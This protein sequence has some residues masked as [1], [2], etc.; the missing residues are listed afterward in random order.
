MKLNKQTFRYKNKILIEKAIF[1][2][3]YRHERAVQNEGC[4]VYVQGTK[5]KIYSS[6]DNLKIENKEAILLKCDTYFFDFIQESENQSVEVIA[7]HLYPEILRKIY[8][9]E[10]PAIID[11]QVSNKK[12]KH[13]ADQKIISKFIESLEFYFENPS[14]VNDDLLELKIKELVLL[15][16]QTKNVA[17]ILE[18][19]ANLYSPRVANLKNVIELHLY[20]NLSIEELAK[21]CHLSVSSFKR[22]FKKQFNDSPAN[23]INT[24]KI[25]KAKGLLSFSK[26][27]I[28][29]VAFESGFNDP[30][31]FTRLFKK[32]EGMPPSEFQARQVI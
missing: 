27:P 2:P 3:P 28:S 1:T 18:L 26:L 15:L 8:I 22:E 23:Y 10:L 29:E 13:I 25:E 4:F 21:L 16:V 30:Q 5:T 20:A 32:K 19:V 6:D 9:N 31:Y 17:S 11:K 24:K 14:L 12:T 7:V